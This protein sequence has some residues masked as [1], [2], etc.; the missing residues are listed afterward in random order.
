M[1]TH[2]SSEWPDDPFECEVVQS[3][4]EMSEI[5]GMVFNNV[6]LP[7]SSF[8]RLPDE[9]DIIIV[10][11][12]LIYTLDCKALAPGKYRGGFN[13]EWEHLAPD[14]TD[15]EVLPSHLQLSKISWKKRQVF[16][17][18]LKDAGLNTGNVK[19]I[20]GVVYPDGRDFEVLDAM[21]DDHGI[22]HLLCSKGQLYEK[23][24][25]DIARGGSRRGEKLLK[26]G[27][28]V[29]RV[30]GEKKRDEGRLPGK[31]T[32]K[33]VPLP[34]HGRNHLRGS[35]RGL[36]KDIGLDIMADVIP[37]RS[38]PGAI[39]LNRM[40]RNCRAMYLKSDMNFTGVIRYI[41]AEEM[42][43]AYVFIYEY[44]SDVQLASTQ[45][46]LTK[47]NIVAIMIKLVTALYGL[48][49]RGVIHHFLSPDS[50]LVNEN[51]DVRV[52]DLYDI[53]V[54]SFSINSSPWMSRTSYLAPEIEQGAPSDPSMDIYSMGSIGRHLSEINGV[55]DKLF[56][57]LMEEMTEI[58]VNDRLADMK[59]I[60]DRLEAI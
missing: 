29:K 37:K 53:K 3:L 47:K 38:G 12:G 45:G 17:G 57:N 8:L 51:L 24:R 54:G 43:S 25:E 2:Q 9:Q 46:N 33:P 56:F 42:P 31:I 55:E 50:I 30:M 27:E 1:L 23:L 40:F 15:W 32:L 52:I 44:F 16:L 4:C 36:I 21:T 18:V 34:F 22:R 5:E 60:K 41:Q 58:S 7:N 13:H 20:S 14:D 26:V 59:Q 10:T 49:Q 19:L 39:R 35:Y 11:D 48:H 6:I 28:V